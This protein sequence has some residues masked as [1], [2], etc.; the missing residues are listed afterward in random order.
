[1]TRQAVL[2]SALILCCIILIGGIMMSIRSLFSFGGY[3]YANA[4]KYTSGEA[5][6]TKPVRNL[7]IDWLDGKV[8]ILYHGGNTIALSEKSDREISKDMEVRWRLDGDTLRI[9]YAKPGFRMSRLPNKELT[10]ILPESIVLDDVKVSATSGTLSI[11]ALRSE[12]IKLN[13]TS[14]DIFA[15]VTV[16]DVSAETTSGHSDLQVT[17]NAK[18]VTAVTTSGSIEIETANVDRFSAETTSGSI[19]AILKN[20]GEFKAA[21]TS[22]NISADMIKAKNADLDTTSG[23]IR[24]RLSKLGSLK[25]KT[26]SGSV[27]AYLPSNPGFT[28]QL[29]TTS[30]QLDFDLPLTQQKG[31]Y[32]C[33]D[34]SGKVEIRTTSG[35]IEISGGNK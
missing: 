12:N 3:S 21:T 9:R 22:G 20:T 7:D 4:G 10:L 14:G 30:G 33:G 1:M 5:E 31:S 35:N 16:K 32:V 11:P 24:L 2:K 13:V 34:G 27:C 8:S 17:D 18:E 23:D 6:I 19:Q 15:S 26:T 25:I 28:A 29:E